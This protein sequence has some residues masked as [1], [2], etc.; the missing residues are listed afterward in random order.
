MQCAL[1][2]DEEEVTHTAPALITVTA[3]HL[4]SNDIFCGCSVGS[5]TTSYASWFEVEQLL[6]SG[7]YFSSTD[8][9]PNCVDVVVDMRN[10]NWHKKR[11]NIPY[12]SVVVFCHTN[13]RGGLRR[14]TTESEG[15]H[16]AGNGSKI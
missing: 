4:P 7:T 2:I 11:G 8:W 3:I 1:T 10:R 9:F 16:A 15:S 5:R 13:D 6:S 12:P 14:E